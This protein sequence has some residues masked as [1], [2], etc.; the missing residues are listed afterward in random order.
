MTAE[1]GADALRAI[2][3]DARRAHERMVRADMAPLLALVDAVTATV[4]ASGRIFV[5]GNGGS[6]ADAQHLAAELVG[7]FMRER[8]AIGAV[9][10]S[11]DTSILTAV[12]N[13]YGFDRVFARQLEALARPGDLALAITTSG[14]SPNLVEGLKTARVVGA[15]TAAFTG[16][17]GGLVAGLVDFHVNVAE[18]T[19]ARVQEVQRTLMHALCELVE[20]EIKD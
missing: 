17:D 19:P 20:S 4:A 1:K 6:A 5:F 18:T 2:L 13:D 10:L 9:A 7:R 16:G 12:S 3:E 14:R 11:T 15:R 8:R